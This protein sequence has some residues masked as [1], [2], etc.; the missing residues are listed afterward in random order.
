M[1]LK[2]MLAISVAAVLM[3][4][5]T[6]HAEVVNVYSGRHYQ[7]DE[8]L[9]REFTEQTGIRVN[10]V[11]ANSDQLLN[12][13]EME[14]E[15]S[16]ADIIITADAGRLIIAKEKGLLQPIYSEK[17]TQLVPLHF[18]DS[19]NFWLGFT[20]RAR[21]IIYPKGRINPSEL[22]SYESLTENHW[23]GRV[24]VRSSQNHYNQTLMASVLAAHGGEGAENWA[25]GI[26]N[27][28]ARNPIGNDRDQIKG[29]AAGEGD[30]AIANTYYIGL[31]LNSVNREEREVASQMGVFFPNQNDR[32]THVNI[33]GIGITANSPNYNNAVLL[34]EFLLSEHAQN[35]FASE[36]YEYP[37]NP[38]VEWPEL[39]KSWGEFKSD[40][41]PL[42]NLGEFIHQAMITFNNAGWE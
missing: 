9:F 13:L 22:D 21:V 23:N 12:R 8:R 27:N 4:G 36:N 28:M 29:I 25:R 16:P 11:K 19:E 3:F 38:N 1:L 37:V 42:H 39:L 34:T 32:G 41:L 5:C 33:S 40:T 31:M 6:R 18:R 14:G 15:R 7:A 26:V 30:I 2:R 35:V 17:A 10:L 20:K 24:L